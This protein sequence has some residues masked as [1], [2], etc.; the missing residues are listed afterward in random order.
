[1]GQGGYQRDGYRPLGNARSVQ[2]SGYPSV[3]CAHRRTVTLPGVV[4]GFAWCEHDIRQVW[5]AR[6][7]CYYITTSRAP[8]RLIVV[9]FWPMAAADCSGPV[10]SRLNFARLGSCSTGVW[11]QMND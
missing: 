7:V 9:H 8:L 3:K 4:Q 11:T 10:S 6:V 1:M 5:T 2:R